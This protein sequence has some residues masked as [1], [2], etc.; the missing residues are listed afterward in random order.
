MTRCQSGYTPATGAVN[1]ALKSA[2]SVAVAVAVAVAVL[3]GVG[4]AVGVEGSGVEVAVGVGAAVGVH[5]GVNVAVNVGVAAAVGVDVGV[6]VGAGATARSTAHAASTCAAKTVMSF[7]AGSPVV[8]GY[9]TTMLAAH[10][11]VVGAGPDGTQAGFRKKSQPAHEAIGKYVHAFTTQ[12]AW[13]TDGP[14]TARA[15]RPADRAMAEEET[16]LVAT[17]VGALE[18]PPP[19]P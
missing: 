8:Y 10:C 15:E 19:T 14:A 9:P 12:S 11:S 2:G 18:G 5:V 17:R 4:M 13:L 6:P 3:V 16:A 1:V 7:G